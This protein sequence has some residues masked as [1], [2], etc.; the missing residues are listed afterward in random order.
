MLCENG[1]SK[2]YGRSYQIDDGN[3]L[4]ILGIGSGLLSVLVLMLY[5]GSQNVQKLYETPIMLTAIGPLMLYWISNIWFKAYKGKISED[6]VL[7]TIKDKT[8]YLVAFL[9]FL[10]ATL[11]SLKL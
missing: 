11:S 2:I 7:Y 3:I 6:P 5:T 8:S 9:I 4:L 1:S 10:V